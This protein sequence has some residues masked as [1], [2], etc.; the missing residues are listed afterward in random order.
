MA[1]LDILGTYGKTIGY[2]TALLIGVGFGASLEMSGF[3]DS[4]KLSAQFYFKDMTVLKVMF[5]AIIVAMALI[6]L[7]SSL[8]ILDFK[9]VYV[10]K[11]Y[12]I[13]GIVGGLIMGVGFIVGGFCP[14][15]SI[16]ATSTLKIDGFVFVS[17][18]AFGTFIFGESLPSF[19]AFST[20]SYM[21]RYILPEWL[22]LSTGSTVLLVIL[23]ALIMF[24]GAGISERVFGSGTPFSEIKLIPNFSDVNKM[25][26]S[27]SVVLI[28]LAIIT[29]VI[30]QPDNNA[31]WS[32]I[33]KKETEKIS[34]REIFIHPGELIETMND[35]M[36]YKTILDVRNEKDY[37][38]FHLQDAVNISTDEAADDSFI[39]NLNIK[40][41]NNV[42]ILVSNDEKAALE[43]YKKLRAQ[44]VIN[45]Y[46][47]SGG[48]NNWLTLF[49]LKKEIASKN[50]KMSDGVSRF[51]FA[52]NV[53]DSVI[54]ANPAGNMHFHAKKMVFEKKIK[55]EKKAIISGGCS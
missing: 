9:R 44:G 32:W 53:G 24:Y 20:S 26:L 1:P 7:S 12:L 29:M 48:V 25:I 21:G 5:T 3:G 37:K 18:V 14:G 36:L 52:K 50:N 35:P 16:V 42:N 4:R 41:S 38:H 13:P 17:G 28:L 40:P 51:T 10:N 6:F 22:G 15:T 39:K 8:Q 30:G 45:L 11:T 47:L 23:M 27:A 55:I 2:I 49:P 34:K 54:Q 46:I 19:K 43:I 31:R 33:K